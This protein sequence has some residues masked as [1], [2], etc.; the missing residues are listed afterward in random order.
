M[1]ARL[2]GVTSSGDFAAGLRAAAAAVESAR[3]RVAAARER[4]CEAS[5]RYQ[6]AF[7][8]SSNPA[9]EE[10]IT[11]CQKA[12]ELI[13]DVLRLLDRAVSDLSA[14]MADVLG[15]QSPST[16]PGPGHPPQPRPDLATR[17]EPTKTDRLKEHL[18]DRDLDAARREL[19]GEVVARKPN[20]T[21]WDHVREVQEAQRGLVNRVTRL[22]RQLEDGRTSDAEKPAIE[23]ELSQ[24]SRLLDHS[25]RFVPRTAREQP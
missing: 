25:E 11:A 21:P 22:Q 14:Y 7:D 19:Q 9:A 24:A 5:D 3:S 6:E 4:G 20:G 15:E 1:L 17:A 2:V 13:D 10:S 23:T 8:G 16:T 18:S 12:L